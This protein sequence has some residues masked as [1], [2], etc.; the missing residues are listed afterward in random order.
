MFGTIEVK[1]IGTEPRR[2]KS[3]AGEDM[4]FPSIQV[5]VMELKNFDADDLAVSMLKEHVGKT[6]AMPVEISRRGS[7]VDY[8]VS[9]ASL[10]S[11]S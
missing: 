7:F 3:K 6:M 8:R 9:G 5:M 4:E 11:K 10:K 1:I 2:F